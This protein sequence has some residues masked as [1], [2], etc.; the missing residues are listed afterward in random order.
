MKYLH[1]IFGNLRRRWIRSLLTLASIAVAFFLFGALGA[2]N[3]AFQAGI[4]LAGQDRLVL[5]HKV[6]LIQPLP[7]SYLP[8]IE[9]VEGVD[10]AAYASWFGGSYQ[11][12]KLFFGKIAVDP[13]DYFD[14]YPEIVIPEEQMAAWKADRIGAL[15]GED[16]AKKFG[17]QVG[18]RIPIIGDIWRNEGDRPWE[19]NIVGIYGTAEGST[20]D[21]MTFFFRQDYLEEA[22]TQGKG[23]VGWYVIRVEDPEQADQVAKRIDAMFANSSYETNTSTE[24]AF[25]QGFA[26]QIGNTT[27]IIRAVFVVVFFTMLLVAGNTMAQAVRERTNELA[28]LK[29]M[30]FSDGKVVFLVLAEACV[31]AILGGGLGLGLAAVAVGEAQDMVS[32]VFPVFYL[33]GREV[34][35]GAV[36]ILLLGLLTGALPAWQAMRLRVADAL[37]RA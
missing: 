23:L 26:Q 5:R 25:V 6:S 10:N 18:D 29:A 22:R 20:A 19:F 1:L 34:A 37:R 17:W 32:A 16:L 14:I 11:D 24:L 35:L 27:A 8:R 33:P 28:V 3:M 36:Y 30:G 15:V 9:G 12:S 7:E 4:E 31:L 21:K 13:E 2:V